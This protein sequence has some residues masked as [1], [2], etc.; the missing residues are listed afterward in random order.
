MAKAAATKRYRRLAREAVEAQRIESGPWERA[1]VQSRF[2]HKTRRRR[3][4]VNH[5]AMLKSAYDGV[6]DAGLLADDDSEHLTTLPASFEIDRHR[7]RVEIVFT[8]IK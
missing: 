1:T 5:V 8:K 3:D 7:P 6:V 2:F 4:D